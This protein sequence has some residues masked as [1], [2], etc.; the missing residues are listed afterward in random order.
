MNPNRKRYSNSRERVQPPKGNAADVGYIRRSE[1]KYPPGCATPEQR[2]AFDDELIVNYQARI[3]ERATAHGRDIAKWYIDLDI[4]GRAYALEKREAYLEL[5]DEIEAGNIRSVT[6]TETSRISREVVIFQTF[7]KTCKK[8]G[9]I[10]DAGNMISTGSDTTDDFVAG[11][12]ALKDQSESDVTRIRI[13]EHNHA[14]VKNR[15]WVGSNINAWGLLYNAEKNG[16]DP[17]PATAPFVRLMFD[18]F[19]EQGGVAGKVAT[20]LNGMIEAGDPRAFKAGFVTA[21]RP[22]KQA[23]TGLWRSTTILQIIRAARYRRYIDYVPGL[24]YLAPLYFFCPELIPE[25]I[26]KSVAGEVDRLLALRAPANA[27]TGDRIKAGRFDYTYTGLFMCGICGTR[28]ISDKSPPP[29]GSELTQVLSWRCTRIYQLGR[30]KL[31]HTILQRRIDVLVGRSLRRWINSQTL[32]YAEAIAAVQPA[33][34]RMARRSQ[35]VL[36]KNTFETALTD[37]SKRRDNTYA[38]AQRGIVDLDRLETMLKELGDE[39][40]RVRE[41]QR[42]VEAQ[43]KALEGSG[44]AAAAAAAQMPILT[45]AEIASFS[46]VLDEYW[47]LSGDLALDI[48]KRVF[49]QELGA[50]IY[51]SAAEHQPEHGRELK[52][53]IAAEVTVEIELTKYG[54]SRAN[55]LSLVETETPEEYAEYLE[56]RYRQLMD[57]G[58]ATR[59]KKGENR[60]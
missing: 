24:K 49:L 44:G 60:H 16:Y 39:E 41:Q 3:R 40:A 58:K 38:M 19:I 42:S 52:Y 30:C 47:H 5:M 59:F 25:I 50:V 51:V 17:D 29:S 1:V 31:S 26:P 23:R 15:Q 11:I 13:I 36:D 43:Q 48:P 20:I 9:V 6:V 4:S 33:E 37:I 53:R 55:K 34:K 45:A 14:A 7:R 28:M 18:L 21:G 35:T 57:A 54:Y 22:Q 32:N 12:M 2:R 27:E 10:F 56:W 46:L 8:H